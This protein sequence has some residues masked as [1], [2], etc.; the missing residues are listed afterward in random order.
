MEK[1]RNSRPAKKPRKKV[2]MFCADRIEKIDYKD[3]AK[4][5]K[6]MTERAKILPRRVTGTCAYHQRE[7]TVA[8]KRARHIALLPHISD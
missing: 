8:I 5:R 3:L 6:C 4:L 7:L 2:C 1:E